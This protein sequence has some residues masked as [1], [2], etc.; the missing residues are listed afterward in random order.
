M[1]RAGAPNSCIVQLLWWSTV[2]ILIISEAGKASKGR[3]IVPGEYEEEKE[4][5]VQG[6]WNTSIQ[7][8]Y[9][10]ATVQ[11]TSAKKKRP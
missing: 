3:E 5:K 8:V 1:K 6:L 4:S 7:G 10:L 11:N 2:Y 9:I